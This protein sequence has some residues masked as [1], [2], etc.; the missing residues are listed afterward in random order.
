LRARGLVEKPLV[1]VAAPY[2][3]RGLLLGVQDKPG[4]RRGA[5][6]HVARLGWDTDPSPVASEAGEDKGS[7]PVG[8]C[9]REG[10]GAGCWAAG[11]AGS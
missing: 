9:G 5:A 10:G 8:D 3:G 6:R 7:P 1:E 2:K 4:M 11:W